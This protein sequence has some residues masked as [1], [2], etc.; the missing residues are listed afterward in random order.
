[1]LGGLDTGLKR[2]IGTAIAA[3]GVEARLAGHKYPAIHPS[4]ICNRGRS[5]AGVQVELTSALRLEQ[6][7][8]AFITAI[9]SVLLTL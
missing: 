9:R 1:L 3:A 8:H 7:N 5:G 2:R 6:A 4:N